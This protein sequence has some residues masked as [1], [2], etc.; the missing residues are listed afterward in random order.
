MG[1]KIE[2]EKTELPRE[3]GR[4]TFSCHI[5]MLLVYLLVKII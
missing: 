5:M 2:K 1:R 4:K 3:M